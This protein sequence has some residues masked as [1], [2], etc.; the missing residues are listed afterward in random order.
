MKIKAF[1]I[2]ELVVALAI[3]AFIAS[4]GYYA[5]NAVGNTIRLK[6]ENLASIEQLQ[7]LRFVLKQDLN[8]HH[9]WNLLGN[10]FRSETAR[11]EYLFE[12]K[13]I[14]RNRF[15]KIQRFE[16]DSVKMNSVWNNTIN[17]IEQINLELTFKKNQYQ[18]FFHV[19]NDIL[20]FNKVDLIETP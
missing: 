2:A 16:C 6:N 7:E 12:K 4:L 20:L 11:I 17:N 15:N 8:Q 10:R 1:T 5:I 19:N 18:L 13:Y 14:E 3:S 9:D